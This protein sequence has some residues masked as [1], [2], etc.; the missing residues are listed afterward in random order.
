MNS[1]ISRWLVLLLALPV[2]L[3]TMRVIRAAGGQLR[4]EKMTESRVYAY[5]GWQSMGVQLD[6]NKFV[7]I[8]ANGRWSFLPGLE[9]GPFGHAG[10]RAPSRY[11]LPQVPGGVLLGRIGESGTPF[12]V[13]N[14]HQMKVRSAGLLYLRINDDI[15]SDNEGVVTISIAVEDR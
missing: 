1:T 7:S 15:L 3:G 14:R 8:R 2:L 4:Q 10:H 6:E 9:H 12:V 11:P 13:G 5:R